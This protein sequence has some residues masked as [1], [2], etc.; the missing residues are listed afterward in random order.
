MT[1]PTPSLRVVKC[2]GR[3]SVTALSSRPP[4]TNDHLLHIPPWHRPN[5]LLD[6]TI[7]HNRTSLLTWALCVPEELVRACHRP[8]QTNTGSSFTSLSRFVLSLSTALGQAKIPDH[9]LNQR[10]YSMM[11]VWSIHS[12]QAASSYFRPAYTR[13]W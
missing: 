1:I 9:D 10:R 13:Q 7:S 2:R 12:R 5:S 11:L 4:S 8:V 6:F 3:V